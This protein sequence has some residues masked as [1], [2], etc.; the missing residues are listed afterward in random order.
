[1][2]NMLRPMLLF[3]CIL[4]SLFLSTSAQ[5]CAKYAFPKNQVFSACND[6][7]FLDSFLHWTYNPSTKTVQIAYRHTKIT[8]SKWVAWAI[9]P[10]S[11]GMVGAQAL[12]AFRKS[13]GTVRAY[14]SP[15]TS[16]ST[17]LQ[18]G[19][20][21]FEVSGLSATFSKDEMT[22]F[23][24][25]K[26][27]SNGTTV[28]Q[29][30]QEGPLSGNAPKIHETSGPNVQS[31]GTLN[32]ASGKSVTTG[33]SNSKTK[34]R[35]IHGILN[36]VGWGVMMPMGAIIARYLRVFK[37]ADPAWFY[38]HV[39]CQLSA[40]IAGVAGWAIGIQLGNESPGTQ[41]P[42]HRN[43]GIVLFCFGT[44][45]VFALLLRPNK[46]HKYRFYWNMYHHSIGYSTII[47]S[48]INIFKGFDILKPGKM[49]EKIYVGIL[50]WLAFNAVLLEAYTWYIVVKRK[51]TSNMEKMSNGNDGLY[52]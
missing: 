44:L 26:L 30:W 31:M 23:A 41:Y 37:R 27:P 39:S 2:A 47:L 49:W 5:S 51:K 7:P 12:V 11:K 24:T 3:S 29:V 36:T 22:I 13:D 34:R 50:V 6:L 1:M 21:A 15:V 46:D 35:N 10:S 38:L 9:N 8:S 28:N 25:L 40:Y 14:T 17:Q 45:Q 43:I 48:I 19:K 16:Y 52:G 20:L 32:L 4:I 33:G 18:E 42:T